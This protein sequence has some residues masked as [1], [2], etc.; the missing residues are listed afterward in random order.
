[1]SDA[2]LRPRVVAAAVVLLLGAALAGWLMRP[3]PVT[4]AD[5]GPAPLNPA[6]LTSPRTLP[7]VEPALQAALAQQ[8]SAVQGA[9]RLDWQSA[10]PVGEGSQAEAQALAERLNAGAAVPDDVPLQVHRAQPVADVEAAQGSGF[11][12][13]VQAL[14]PGRWVAVAQQGLWRAVRRAPDAAP[15]AA[16][17]PGAR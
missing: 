5:D 12:A 9:G 7:A 13:R 14:P 16:D 11:A 4:T 8:R 1:M 17:Q 3:A 2:V 6:L 15:Q 10:G